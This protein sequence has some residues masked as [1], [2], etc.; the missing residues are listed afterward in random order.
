MSHFFHKDE[1]ID[2]LNATIDRT[3]GEVDKNNVFSKT[4]GKPKITGI[5]G[6][7]IEQSV[8]GY[9]ADQDQRPDLDVDGVLTELKTTGMR[10][11]RDGNR[12]YF[13][14]KE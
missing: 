13:E 6:D 12:Q 8:L 1:L 10:M 4:I 3:F 11:R 7:V 5:A 9:P 2:I 14:A